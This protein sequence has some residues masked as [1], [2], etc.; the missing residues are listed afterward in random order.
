MATR[1][2]RSSISSGARAARQEL[3]CCY[4]VFALWGWDSLIYNH[5]TPKVADNIPRDIR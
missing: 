2:T 1:A 5:L 4:R 3:A